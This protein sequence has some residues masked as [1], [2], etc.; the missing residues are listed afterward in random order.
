MYFGDRAVRQLDVQGLRMRGW[1]GGRL[2]NVE[3]MVNRLQTTN[4]DITILGCRKERYK[5]DRNENYSSSRFPNIVYSNN[6]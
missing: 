4:N 5:N 2:L 3:H 6:N 1:N